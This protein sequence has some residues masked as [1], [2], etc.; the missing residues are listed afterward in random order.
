MFA[1]DWMTDWAAPPLLVGGT[2]LDDRN[3]LR[4]FHSIRPKAG[5]EAGSWHS[6]RHAAATALLQAGVPMP[7]VSAILGHGSITV[8]VD[9]YGH[10]GAGH[11]AEEMKRGLAGYGRPGSVTQSVT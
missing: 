10:V 9:L 1:S 7:T 6:L 4:W 3:A 5:I 8:T 11:M 2:P